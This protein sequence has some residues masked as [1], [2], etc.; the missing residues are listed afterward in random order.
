MAKGNKLKVKTTIS[1]S[2]PAES[3]DE[4]ITKQG[5][6]KAGKQAAGKQ[7]AGKQRAGKQ[8]AG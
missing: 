3:L 8:K 5:G 7:A 4:A 1:G 2:V 6:N